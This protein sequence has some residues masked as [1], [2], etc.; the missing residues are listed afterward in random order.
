M[1]DQ[2]YGESYC[3]SGVIKRKKN[4]EMEPAISALTGLGLEVTV[5]LLVGTV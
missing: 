4:F 5:V 1:S 2:R 3:V